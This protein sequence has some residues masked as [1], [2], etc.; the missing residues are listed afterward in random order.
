[1]ELMAHQCLGVVGGASGRKKAVLE[2]LTNAPDANAPPPAA[3]HAALCAASEDAAA[4]K[5]PKRIRLDA[6]LPTTA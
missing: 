4:E 3:A 1:M 6:P 5:A 2:P